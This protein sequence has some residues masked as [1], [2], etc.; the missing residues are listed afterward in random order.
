M[1]ALKK[2]LFVIL[3]TYVTDNVLC[4]GHGNIVPLQRPPFVV[5]GVNPGSHRQFMDEDLGGL[6]EEDGGFCRNHFNVLV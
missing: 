5:L 6:C 3:H 1:S 2:V 4:D